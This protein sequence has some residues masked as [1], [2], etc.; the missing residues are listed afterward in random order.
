MRSACC[1]AQQLTLVSYRI[2]G[3]NAGQAYKFHIDASPDCRHQDVSKQGKAQAH[4]DNRTKL[5]QEIA[6]RILCG[7]ILCGLMRRLQC[8]RLRIRSRI[9]IFHIILR[10]TAQATRRACLPKSRRLIGETAMIKSMGVPRLWYIKSIYAGLGGHYSRATESASNLYP[11][12]TMFRRMSD[13][14]LDYH[15]LLQFRVPTMA[16]LVGLF[17]IG[18]ALDHAVRHGRSRFAGRTPRGV[19]TWQRR[20]P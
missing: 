15:H 20:T 3:V 17:A 14:F 6:R 9:D 5:S 13:W 2:D 1:V 11:P 18:S 7:G 12:S 16:M 19:A 8:A 10:A 4:R